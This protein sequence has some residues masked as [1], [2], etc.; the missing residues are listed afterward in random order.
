M[1]MCWKLFACLVSLSSLAMHLLGPAGPVEGRFC[2]AIRDYR[3]LDRR[4]KSRSCRIAM[5]AACT[6][7]ERF[8]C[9]EQEVVV[10]DVIIFL[11]TDGGHGR[12][13]MWGDATGPS[14]R[15]GAG[16]GRGL[17]N[18]QC[19]S[20]PSLTY[21][22]HSLQGELPKLIARRPHP[23]RR[24]PCR[25]RRSQTSLS[26]GLGSRDGCSRSLS[27]MSTALDTGSWD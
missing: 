6:W 16:T 24:P 23:F 13:L 18:G 3:L 2:Y 8:E 22:I 11:Y 12:S 4:E 1:S 5:Y 17:A 20:L 26:N 9:V 10:A 19:F 15:L 27:G 7:R 21:C 14:G 25:S